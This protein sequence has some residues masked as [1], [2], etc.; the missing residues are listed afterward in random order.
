MATFSFDIV[1]DINLSEINNVLD[2]VRREI[3]NRYDFKNKLVEIDFIDNSKNGFVLT[4]END[5]LI[6]SLLEIIRKKL[7][8]RNLSQKILDLNQPKI[9]SNLKIKYELP[10]IKGLDQAKTKE[11]NNLIR[12]NFPKVKTTNNKDNI[13]VSANSKDELQ[14]TIQML[15]TSDLAYPIQFINFH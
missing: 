10:F 6:D 11:L 13:R 7:A 2:Q 9:E 5:L 12:T 3:S 14:K 15:R 4:A 8:S 1:S